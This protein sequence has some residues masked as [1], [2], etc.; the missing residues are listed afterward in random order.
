M[1]DPWHCVRCWPASPAHSGTL[2]PSK[3]W[4]CQQDRPDSAQ[5]RRGRE[6]DIRRLEID[7][8]RVSATELMGMTIA[9]A[10]PVSY[11]YR[12]DPDVS[13]ERE[14]SFAAE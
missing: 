10:V 5:A 7:E 1:F 12:A 14:Q 11:F 9:L 3:N 2:H 8:S 4:G 6:D 13:A